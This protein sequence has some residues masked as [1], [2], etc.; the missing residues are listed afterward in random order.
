MYDCQM[1]AVVILLVFLGFSCGC[2]TGVDHLANRPK[3]SPNFVEL[4]DQR[5]MQVDLDQHGYRILRGTIIDMETGKSVTGW[6]ISVHNL[7]GGYSGPP[8]GEH[9]CESH[10]G[11]SGVFHV[12]AAPSLYWNQGWPEEMYICISPAVQ[13]GGP[14]GV[15][16]Y[17]SAEMWRNGLW[18]EPV[19][20]PKTRDAEQFYKLKLE[21][22]TPAANPLP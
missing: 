20:Q 1:K 2:Q 3:S 7:I 10:V 5:K 21:P 4:P 17:I 6:N 13:H 16:F 9:F 18:R 11:L 15:T 19:F 22:D 12:C 14:Y 8:L